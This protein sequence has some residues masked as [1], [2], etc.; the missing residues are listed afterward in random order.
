MPSTATGRA[1]PPAWRA[2]QNALPE[3]RE[4][5]EIRFLFLPDGDD[6]DTLVGEEGR[7]AF[8]QRLDTTLPLSEYLVEIV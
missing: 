2:L 8:E 4:G 6:P 1:A 3:A 5:R 7:E